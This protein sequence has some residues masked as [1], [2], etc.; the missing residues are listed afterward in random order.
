MDADCTISK[1]VGKLINLYLFLL[2]IQEIDNMM[3]I[4]F[5]FRL[6]FVT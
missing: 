2:K 5:F 4:F 6:S 3:K 1:S